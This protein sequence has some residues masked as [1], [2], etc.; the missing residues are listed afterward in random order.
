MIMAQLGLV[1]TDSDTADILNM[2][3]VDFDV[4][5][6]SDATLANAAILEK[7]IVD[8]MKYRAPINT[9]LGFLS[10]IKS[11]STLSKQTELVDN[12]NEYY[13]QERSVMEKLQEA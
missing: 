3:L 7:Q 10:S 11:F 5:K 2:E 1:A 6:R 4:S 13:K 12:R 9:G 8:F